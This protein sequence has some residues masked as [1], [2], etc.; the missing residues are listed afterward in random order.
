MHA[1]FDV[2]DARLRRYQ[3]E[4]SPFAALRDMSAESL[5]AL[6]ASVKASGNLVL[7]QAV[8][9]FEGFDLPAGL[10]TLW[11]RPV[12]QMVF[13][14]DP[15][16]VAGKGEI[17]L[18]RGEDTPE[19]LALA[20]LAKPG[21]FASRT[22][23]M[24]HYWGVRHEGHLIAM[25]GERMRQPGFTEI[26]AICTHP[27]H[28]GQGLGRALTIHAI[29]AILERGETP[30]LHVFRDNEAAIALYERL[31]FRWRQDFRGMELAAVSDEG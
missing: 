21:P 8:P 1:R 16:D 7:A 27:D 6:T 19:M 3:P 25:A 4:V 10:R 13:D 30:F 26:S 14:A 28:R 12:I 20:S 9:G 5:A 18:L 31:G 2:G 11:D 22:R 24:G 17:V 15:P 29:R 23:E